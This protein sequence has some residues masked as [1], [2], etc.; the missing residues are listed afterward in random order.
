[1]RNIDNTAYN[2]E[3]NKRLVKQKN[4]VNS[5]SPANIDAVNK[6]I[7]DEN[8]YFW[9]NSATLNGFSVR[10]LKEQLTYL[11]SMKVEKLFLDK[12]FFIGPDVSPETEQVFEVAIPS[13]YD[14]RN[15]FVVP[16]LLLSGTSYIIPAD[17]ANIYMQ[18]NNNDWK[19]NFAISQTRSKVNIKTKGLS[20]NSIFIKKV[21]EDV[22]D[23]TFLINVKLFLWRFV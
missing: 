7:V 20:P 5:L 15:C 1:M 14:G 13:G 3:L 11:K 18:Q 23:T 19:F 9:D 2:E 10:K 12:F 6:D 4:D 16:V 17:A 22:Q 8:S 21:D